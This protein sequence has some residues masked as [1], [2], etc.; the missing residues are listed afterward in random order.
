MH[1]LPKLR[2]QSFFEFDNK[3]DIYDLEQAKDRIDYESESIILLEGQAVNSHE[4]LV[5]L[6]TKEQY[7]DKEFLEVVV[8]PYIVGG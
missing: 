4:E 6:A 1:K 2:V 8:L 3:A 5:Q 7:K